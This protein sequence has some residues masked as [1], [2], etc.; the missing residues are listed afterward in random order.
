LLTTLILILIYLIAGLIFFLI[1]KEDIERE[2]STWRFNETDKAMIYTLIILTWLPLVLYT[3][4]IM[5]RD[6]RS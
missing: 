3:L 4:T 1:L 6:K 2:A 5:F